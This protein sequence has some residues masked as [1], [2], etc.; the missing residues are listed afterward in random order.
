M[1]RDGIYDEP[2]TQL[3]IHGL[4]PIEKR[5]TRGIRAGAS[6]GKPGAIRYINNFDTKTSAPLTGRR[7]FFLRRTARR[8]P[9]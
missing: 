4:S 7:V 5:S 1:V 2:E 8:A 6:V 9:W 3:C